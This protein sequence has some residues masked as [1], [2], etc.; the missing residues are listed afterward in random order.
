MT[1]LRSFARRSGAMLVLY[2]GA[3]GLGFLVGVLL[4]RMLGAH[5]YGIY[6]LAM[7]T[8]TL[9]GLVTEFGLPVLVL[10]ETGKACANSDWGTVRALLPWSDRTVLALSALLA[11]G[12]LL[13][14]AVAGGGADMSL[15]FGSVALIPLVAI[16][17]LRSSA[18][19]AMDAVWSG[20][21]PMM[22]LR[23]AL[24]ALACVV[25]HTLSAPLRPATAMLAQ[26]LSAGVATAILIVLF[27]RARPAGWAG[28]PPR[29]AVREWLATCL[30]MGLTEGLRLLQ[31]QFGLLLVGALTG[32]AAAGVYRVGD[33]VAQVTQLAISVVA[34]AATSMF[35]RLHAEGDLARLRQIAFLSCLAA[36]VGSLALGL[37]VALF[38][39][40]LFQQIF[41]HDFSPSSR[42]FLILWIGN[43]IAA[44]TG[45]SLT[46]ANM[47]GHHTLST[48]GFIVIV[49]VNAGIGALV[50]PQWGAE[51]AAFASALALV[52][53]NAWTAARLLRASGI[54]AT[55]FT[56]DGWSGLYRQLAAARRAAPDH[57]K[58]ER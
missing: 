18:L 46:I 20:Q 52:C 48:Q 27:R 35:A 14:Q 17:K 13:W 24:F 50:V 19:L 4:A 51:G 16:G 10:R 49:L 55:L 3:N 21:A 26:C 29:R 25:L 22:V 23:P 9:A 44:T 28:I 37:P 45:L 32:A 2:V 6:A 34:T 7:T 39:E 41:G 36:L 8:A 58:A 47:I 43:L 38:G 1:G 31:G 54:N 42:V 15:L 40:P 57:T 11:A 30:P 53:G 56:K 33:A 5:G 12:L